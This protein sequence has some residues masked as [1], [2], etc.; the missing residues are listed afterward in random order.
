LIN[1]TRGEMSLVGPKRERPGIVAGLTRTILLHSHRHS[2]RPGITGWAGLLSIWRDGRGCQREA[3]YDVYYIKELVAA[4]GT[5]NHFANRES[6]AVSLRCVLTLR[7]VAPFDRML[8]G[9]HPH[10]IS[11]ASFLF[12][13][14]AS[15]SSAILRIAPV[16][17][18]RCGLARA[19][20]PR[21]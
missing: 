15:M 9:I 13:G 21:T 10:S 20:T 11:L 19:S 7:V 5:A 6:G 17:P 8:R 2:L 4:R 18:V 1:V 12:L 14:V 16:V 3:C